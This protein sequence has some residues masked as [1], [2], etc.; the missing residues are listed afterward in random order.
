MC[1][2]T[3]ADGDAPD[4]PETIPVKVQCLQ[5][6]VSGCSSKIQSL[7][8]ILNEQ[9]H[10]VCTLREELKKLFKELAETRVAIMDIIMLIM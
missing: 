2:C 4:A 6:D 7:S 10:D 1:L 3:H 9:G 5:K 8:V